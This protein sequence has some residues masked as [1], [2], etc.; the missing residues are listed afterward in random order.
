MMK[1]VRYAMG[2]LEPD[3][4]ESRGVARAC[5]GC[6]SPCSLKKTR[7]QGSDAMRGRG[8]IRL[9]VLAGSALALTVGCAIA[10]SD[11][12]ANYPNR[13]VRLI[14]GF[15]AGGGTGATARIGGPELGGGVG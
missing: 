6:L 13:P 4:C 9:P 12:A 5:R 2:S 15:A 14:V 3:A 1:G 8:L 11:P 10:Q 7:C